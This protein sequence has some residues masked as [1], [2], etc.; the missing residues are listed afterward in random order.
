LRELQAAGRLIGRNGGGDSENGRGPKHNCEYSHFFLLRRV[1][2]TSQ[3]GRAHS[4][5]ARAKIEAL[6]SK[7]QQHIAVGMERTI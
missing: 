4:V 3:S 5:S 6:L 2:P 1:L 7:D